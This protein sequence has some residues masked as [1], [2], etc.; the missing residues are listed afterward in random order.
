M[1]FFLSAFQNFEGQSD[2]KDRSFKTVPE[3]R[4]CPAAVLLWLWCSD[5]VVSATYSRFRVYVRK[6]ALHFFFFCACVYFMCFWLVFQCFF[7]K[8]RFVSCCFTL[9]VWMLLLGLMC[10]GFDSGI[11]SGSRLKQARC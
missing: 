3:A 1:I 6:V 9:L 10:S 4:G 2:R 11:C 7:F 5:V 8:A